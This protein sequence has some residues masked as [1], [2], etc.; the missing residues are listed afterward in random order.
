MFDLQKIQDHMR[1]EGIGTWLVYDFRGSNPVFWQLLRERRQTTRRVFLV[2]PATGA[3]RLIGSMVE[4]EALAG[5]G[6]D[7][8][9]YASWV[10]METLLRDAVAGHARVAMEYSPGGA[11]PI[12]SWVDGGTLEL[13]RSLGPEVVSSADLCQ[14]ALAVWSPEAQASHCDACRQVAE[15]KDAAFEH[16]RYGL[17]NHTA[18]SEFGVQEFISA[19]FTRRGLDM[20]H[21]AIV[22]VNQNSGNPHYSP[23]EKN[24][25]P[26]QHGDWVLI[27]LWARH[28]GEQHVFGDITWVGFSGS[29]VPEP[30]AAV[31]AVVREARDRV[32]ERLVEAWREGEELQGW[33]LDRVARDVIEAHGYGE[34]YV[35]RTGHSLGP[36][37]T[38]HALGVNLDDLETHDER[39]ILPGTGFSVE[40]GVYLPEFGVRLEINMYVNPETG[41]E[42]TTPIQDEVVLLV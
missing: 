11:L 18:V 28:P 37:P 23:S 29:R 10:Q 32:V 19:E 41:P 14:I 20:D 40:P 5:L 21:P 34:Q 35:H 13:V 2:I 27:D 31:F 30:Q 26:I 1:A 16:I 4:P 25:V 17:A 7:I 33:Q 24:S 39:Q 3:P 6:V 22:G 12:M 8:T 15:V 9:L 42:V 38:V 36:G